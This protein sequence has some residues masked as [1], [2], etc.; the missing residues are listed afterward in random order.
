V[1][2]GPNYPDE[3]PSCAYVSKVNFP[4]V[5]DK[6]KVDNG[7]AKLVWSRDKSIEV[8]LVHLKMLMAKQE[9]RKLS[10][11]PDSATYN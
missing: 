8:L 2:C 4:F 9:Y 3:P 11:P 7:K 1:T 5:D 10:Q 6:G